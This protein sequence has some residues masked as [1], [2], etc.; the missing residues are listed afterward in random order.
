MAADAPLEHPP[1]PLEQG[2]LRRIADYCRDHWD[3]STREGVTKEWIEPV[4]FKH[5]VPCI[6]G[7]FIALFYWDTYFTN[8][9]LLRQDRVE[10]ARSNCDALL[11]LIGQKGF[12]PNSTF[13]GDD[14]RSQP[15]YL[16]MMVREVYEITRDR[17]WLG[18]AV[19]LLETEYRFWMAKRNTPLGLN[20]H[21][22]SAT[23]DYLLRFYDS[24]LIRRVH[25]PADAPR[26]ERLR[27]AAPRLA[28]AEAGCDFTDRFDGRCADFVSLDLNVLLYRYEENFA[29]FANELGRSG[30]QGPRPTAPL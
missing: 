12:V 14:T 3:A 11:Y 30:G 27:I 21:F 24:P 16:S 5:T 9:G 6:S 20:R 22:H 1:H 29:W 26:E 15:P 17:A 10:L 8:L 2:Q 18:H 23:D 13:K 25:A 28:E 19:P 4:P 7:N